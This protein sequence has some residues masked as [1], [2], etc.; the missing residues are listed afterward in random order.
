MSYELFQQGPAVYLS[1]ILLSLIIT[2]LA[3]GAFPFIFAKTRKAPITK[4]KYRR[5]CY[6]IN[7]A[8]M[9]M[10]IVINGGASNGGPYFLWTWIFSHY[11][12]KILSARGIMTD[13][14]YLPDDPNRLTECKSCG[15][16]DENFFNACPKCGKY[17]K[18]YVYLS[19]ELTVDTDKICFC[20]KCG[21]ELI[22]SSKFCR[23]CGTEIVE[24]PTVIVSES[25]NCE[26]CKKCGADITND[27]DTCHVCGESIIR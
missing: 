10:F 1:V 20:R 7:V 6:G 17:A 18:Q 21:E 12:T 25:D 26:F 2:I 4:K 5:L 24:E 8:V 16:R 3:Y 19:D 22:D 23:K 14:D 13:G 11:G 27:T 9:F 15:Y